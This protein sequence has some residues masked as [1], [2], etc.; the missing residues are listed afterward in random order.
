MGGVNCKLYKSLFPNISEGVYIGHPFHP[1]GTKY[2]YLGNGVSIGN[3]T[4]LCAWDAYQGQ[5][6]TPEL[7]LED[8]VIIGPHAHITA[9]NS[10]RIG[11]GTL[12]GKWVTIT[13]NS[14]GTLAD[15]AELDASPL[16]RPLYSKGRVVIGKNVWIG[17]KAT[18]LPSVTI[19]DGA[20]IGANAVVT[21]DV[22]PYAVVGGNP[23]KIIK[24]LR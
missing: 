9:C 14:H 3:D 10:I 8:H 4:Y 21:K 22:P 13:D 24:K 11:R 1:V 19:G 12:L 23:A 17:D 7:I 15:D 20:I 5:T 2:I 18:I 6:F 16:I